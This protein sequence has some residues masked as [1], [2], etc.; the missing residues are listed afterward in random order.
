[1]ILPPKLAKKA[2]KNKQSVRFYEYPLS[3]FITRFGFLWIKIV[4]MRKK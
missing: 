3:Y 2:R 1:M 4:L